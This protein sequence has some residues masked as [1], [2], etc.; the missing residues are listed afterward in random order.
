MRRRDRSDSKEKKSTDNYKK[1][2]KIV[3]DL[4]E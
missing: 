4:E 2:K 3:T 1:L